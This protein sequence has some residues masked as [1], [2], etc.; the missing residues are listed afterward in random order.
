[1][2]EDIGK[3]KDSSRIG[4][5]VSHLGIVR[6]TSRDGRAVTGIKVRYD[7]GKIEEII[8]D[9]KNLS[10]IIDVLVDT[11]EGQLMVG[12]EI[13][14]VVIGGDI[15][16]NVFPALVETVNRIKAEASFKEESFV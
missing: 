7:H 4:M 15:R 13:L 9:T 14:A 16:E 10:G 8:H 12:D 1:M 6:G 5:I 11:S 2:I 3:H